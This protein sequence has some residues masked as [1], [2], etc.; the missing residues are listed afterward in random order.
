M[1]VARFVVLAAV[2]FTP[3][4][5]ARV[6]ISV[7]GWVCAVVYSNVIS[8]GQ[9]PFFCLRLPLCHAPWRHLKIY[10]VI[11]DNYVQQ[12]WR[13]VS[14]YNFN[15]YTSPILCFV[16]CE[17]RN[18]LDAAWLADLVSCRAYYF[19]TRMILIAFSWGCFEVRN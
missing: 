19:S 18:S 6:L 11:Q 14:V 2:A 5:I 12:M 8:L 13:G 15:F 17:S 4:E 9:L 1:E 10:V 7:R 3:Q 16:T